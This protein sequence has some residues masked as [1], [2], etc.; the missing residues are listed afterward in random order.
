MKKLLFFSFFVGVVVGVGGAESLS[1]FDFEGGSKEM[2]LFSGKV[3]VFPLFPMCCGYG[4]R[5]DAS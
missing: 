1:A 5:Q 2:L 4:Q 3:D